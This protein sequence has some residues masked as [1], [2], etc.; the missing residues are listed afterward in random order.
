MFNAGIKVVSLLFFSMKCDETIRTF[1]FHLFLY[2]IIKSVLDL[3]LDP[4]W[5]HHQSHFYFRCGL[6]LATFEN[7]I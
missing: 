4:V 1:G 3:V 7:Y 6:D 2:P 5:C